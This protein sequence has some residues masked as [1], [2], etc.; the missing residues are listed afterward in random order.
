MARTKA[1]SSRRRSKTVNKWYHRQKE[2]DAMS[3]SEVILHLFSR[4]VSLSNTTTLMWTA[5]NT[6]S[7]VGS[8]AN[9]TSA[10]TVAA[11][12]II[13][14]TTTTTP[15]FSTSTTAFSPATGV[16]D[17]DWS[18]DWVWDHNMPVVSHWQISSH[19]KLEVEDKW[20]DRS[21]SF[22]FHQ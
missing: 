19:H 14:N 7:T 8:T 13:G 1:F 22:R 4:L 10:V 9:A 16:Y 15:T 5:H 17:Q 12:T 20:S 2:T 11:S 21:T 6:N 18:W 3:V